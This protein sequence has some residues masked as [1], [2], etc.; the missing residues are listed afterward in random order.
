MMPANAAA[1]DKGIIMKKFLVLSALVGLVGIG[2]GLV[3]R[4]SDPE[5]ATT[6][7]AAAPE[8]ATTA[9]VINTPTSSPIVTPKLAAKPTAVKVT[10]TTTRQAGS[11]TSTTTMATTSVAPTTT[12]AAPHQVTPTCS[13]SAAPA[14]AG[15]YI[16]HGTWEDIRISS[17]MPKTRTRLTV[18]YPGLN[19]Q[20]WLTTDASGAAKKIFELQD[21][22]TTR[23]SIDFYDAAE[24]HVGGSPTCQTTFMATKG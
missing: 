21:S 14:A 11:S 24:N 9:P 4:Q 15:S 22:G 19:Q 16:G 3:A 8:T 13:T 12:M 20:F 6:V 2:V 10:A 7:A 18:Q 23:L 1:T 5:P 17:N